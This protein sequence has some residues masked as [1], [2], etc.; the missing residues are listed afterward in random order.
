MDVRMLHRAAVAAGLIVAGAV[1]AEAQDP[2]DRVPPMSLRETAVSL[3]RS[4]AANNDARTVLA[5]AQLMITAE[6]TSPGLQR[7]EPMPTD[8]VRRE[9]RQKAEAFTAAGLLRL[10]SRIAVEQ[11]DAP[12]AKAAAELAANAEVGL[13]QASLATELQTAAKA[14]SSTRGS[15]GGPI[16]TDGFLASGQ[17]MEYKVTFEGAHA[18]NKIDVSTNSSN[19]DLDCYLYENKQLV[20]RDDGYGGSCSIKWSQKYT[21]A[22]TLRIRNTG[23]ASYYVL[24]SN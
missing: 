3:A 11:G 18:P 6:R 10:A 13:G 16:W 20:A 15:L 5:A 9:E 17:V 1:Q 14:L 12:I 22:M 19:A 24:I 2:S 4:G 21:G 7:V 8:S 23:V